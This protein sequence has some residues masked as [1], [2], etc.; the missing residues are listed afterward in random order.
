[1][2]NLLQE[3]T[4][5]LAPPTPTGSMGRSGAECDEAAEPLRRCGL[6]GGDHLVAAG[7]VLLET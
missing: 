5:D 1:M 4:T 3:G 7:F 2:G 6:L